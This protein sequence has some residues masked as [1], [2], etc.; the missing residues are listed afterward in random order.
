MEALNRETSHYQPA[1]ELIALPDRAREAFSF[2]V[3]LVCG[4][5]FAVEIEKV[6]EIIRVPRITWLPGAPPHIRG[7]INMRGSILAVADPAVLL[8]NPP[9]EMKPQ[10]RIVVVEGAAVK[11]GL[12]VEEVAGVESSPASALEKSLPTLSGP[13][14][15]II[16][17]QVELEGKLSGVLDIDKLVERARFAGSRKQQPGQSQRREP[18]GNNGN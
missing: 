3:M 9:V 13:Q 2:I 1:A 10:N 11:L 16:V 4:E 17:A 8:S 6:L 12:L 14:R 15:Q 18:G 5:R 7:L